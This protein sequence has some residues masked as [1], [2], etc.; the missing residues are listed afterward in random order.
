MENAQLF[1]QFPFLAIPTLLAQCLTKT[2]R[3]EYDSLY[4]DYDLWS[5]LTCRRCD[6]V[7]PANIDYSTLTQVV[8]SSAQDSGFHGKCSHSGAMELTPKSNDN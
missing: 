6:A 4:V 3:N 7:C 1:V 2:I 8:R 5:C